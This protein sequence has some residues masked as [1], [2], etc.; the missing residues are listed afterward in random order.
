MSTQT[1]VLKARSCEPQ[2]HHNASIQADNVFIV[3][4]PNP[5]PE[6]RFGHS[7]DLIDHE[8][9]LSSKSVTFG[10][11]DGEFGRALKPLLG[12]LPQFNF[13]PAVHLI[14]PGHSAQSPCPLRST[15]VDWHS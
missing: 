9:A 2:E 3:E 14:P 7:G 10:I 6:L 8:A 11:K 15:A 4:A 13:M 5:L 1:S 12:A